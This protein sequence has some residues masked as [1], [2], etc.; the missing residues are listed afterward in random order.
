MS[1]LLSMSAVGILFSEDIYAAYAF[2]RFFLV[3]PVP[4]AP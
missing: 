3:P 1:M 4:V 2:I